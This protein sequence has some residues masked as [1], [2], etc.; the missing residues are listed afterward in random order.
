VEQSDIHQLHFADMMGFVKLNPSCALM[1]ADK[2][3]DL[4]C[5]RSTA[6]PAA[7]SIAG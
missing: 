2:A 5:G 7:G 4:I 1:T 3:S 6:E